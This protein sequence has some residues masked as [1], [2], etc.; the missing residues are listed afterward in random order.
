MDSTEVVNFL[1]QYM[2]EDIAIMLFGVLGIV[3]PFLW[4]I[5]ASWAT[6]RPT[7]WY[8]NPVTKKFVLNRVSAALGKMFGRGVNDCNVKY[9]DNLPPEAIETLR[10]RIE[11]TYPAPILDKDNKG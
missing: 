10:K 2:N 7:T 4:R 1:K 8:W 3:I 5:L 9:Q 11:K 6:N